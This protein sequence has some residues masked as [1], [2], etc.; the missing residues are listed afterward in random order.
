VNLLRL[1][2]LQWLKVVAIIGTVIVAI[3][4]AAKLGLI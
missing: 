2:I 1:S 3:I 4:I